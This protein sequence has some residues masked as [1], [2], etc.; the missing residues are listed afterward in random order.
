MKRNTFGAN[1]AG[2]HSS[3]PSFSSV[4]D[5][6]DELKGWG[7]DMLLEEMQQPR[8]PHMQ[9]LVFSEINRRK[10]D[11][12]R[13]NREKQAQAAP[14]V[15]M[16][17][18]VVMSASA[19]P[20]GAPPGGIPMPPPEGMP[21][22]MPVGM[23]PAGPPA[24]QQLQGP[25]GIEQA[26]PPVERPL[27]G[28]MVQGAN[29]GGLV[30]GYN[31]SQRLPYYWEVDAQRRRDRREEEAKIRAGQEWE[32][33]PTWLGEVPG[34]VGSFLGDAFSAVGEAKAARGAVQRAAGTHFMLGTRAGEE[35]EKSLLV[36]DS[37]SEEVLST[38]D[39]SLVDVSLTSPVD[40]LSTQVNSSQDP[41][42]NAIV[43]ERAALLAKEEAARRAEAERRVAV[44]GRVPRTE[45]P[46][47][48]YRK[49]LGAISAYSG[50]KERE[51]L[52]RR[53]SELEET[54][55]GPS[56]ADKRRNILLALA[57][58]FLDPS[59]NE[60]T[61][62]AAGLG[63]GISNARKVIRNREVSENERKRNLATARIALDQMGIEVFKEEDKSAR[64]IAL[65]RAKGEL[66]IGLAG[67][68]Q[69]S[70]KAIQD[71]INTVHKE[72]AEGRAAGYMKRESL[73][74]ID[75]AILEIE[76]T[77]STRYSL[78]SPD[79]MSDHERKMKE[80]LEQRLQGLYLAR[81]RV[82]G[83]DMRINRDFVPRANQGG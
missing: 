29:R 4:I 76:E 45:D 73:K 33:F 38:Q 30:K 8:F 37:S 59:V 24:P 78:M 52:E 56:D 35:F 15:S 70:A 48:A 12:D 49:S 1:G 44:T 11:R 72:I 51:I 83:V 41:A 42:L 66:E 9:Y 23:P 14:Q 64:D 61:G 31:Q 62:V 80:N 69:A 68:K 16:A 47:D 54:F 17:E 67:Q 13:V 77:I 10:E 19:P 50:D 43:D 58:G 71:S 18:E 5:I 28:T 57:E 60:E 55:A 26:Y 27:P 34:R 3:A 7:D 36:P 63:K 79:Q 40:G 75:K 22:G 20:G 25:V 6:E 32:G 2:G 46:L 81:K 65:A 74:G 82:S 39:P 21:P 53:R